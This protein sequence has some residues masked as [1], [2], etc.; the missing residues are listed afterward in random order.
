MNVSQFLQLLREHPEHT[1][2]FVLS[3]GSTIPPHYH[4]TEVGHAS[5]TFLDCGGK[6]HRTES[7]ILQVW[8][9]DDTDHRLHAKKLVTIFDRATELISDHELPIE[10]EHE[11]PVLTQL[12]ISR[13]E[14]AADSLVFHLSHKHTDCLAKELCTPNFNIPAIPGTCSPAS[15][16]C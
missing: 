16:C 10:I 11:A 15:G 12:T 7:C 14:V 3:D 1:L 8:I 9:A 6:G 5:K 4:I 2:T 13:H